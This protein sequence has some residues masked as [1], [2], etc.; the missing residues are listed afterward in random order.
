MD[1][2]TLHN[3]DESDFR[4]REILLNASLLQTPIAH[5]QQVEIELIKI[6]RVTRD[7]SVSSLLLRDK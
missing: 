2:E 7:P 3:P 4:T 5:A 1:L 6:R